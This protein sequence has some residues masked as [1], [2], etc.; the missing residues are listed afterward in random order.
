MA[1]SFLSLTKPSTWP[2]PTTRSRWWPTCPAQLQKLLGSSD[3][4]GISVTDVGSFNGDDFAIRRDYFT[5]RRVDDTVEQRGLP[6]TFRGWTYSL[7]D[8]A[9]ALEVAGLRIEAM[10]E[11]RPSASLERFQKWQRVPLFLLVRAVKT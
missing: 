9:V 1:P 8:Y 3:L 2:W 6:M 7:E 11:P 4:V 5:I 10:R